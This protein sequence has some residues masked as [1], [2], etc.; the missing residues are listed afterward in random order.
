MDQGVTGFISTAPFLFDYAQSLVEL[1]KLIGNT[2]LVKFLKNFRNFFQ[3]SI[4]DNNE[5]SSITDKFVEIIRQLNISISEIIS[6]DHPNIIN[7][8]NQSDAQIIVRKFK[9]FF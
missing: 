2:N 5:D 3:V 7:V 8:L 6:V 1:L 4:V 9:N